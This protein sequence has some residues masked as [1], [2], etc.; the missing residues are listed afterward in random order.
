MKKEEIGLQHPVHERLQQIKEKYSAWNPYFDK[1][2]DD[3]YYIN[4]IIGIDELP[5]DEFIKK[6]KIGDK[7]V[8]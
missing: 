5:Y 3:E 7:N 8:K 1:G 4:E 6:K 2:I